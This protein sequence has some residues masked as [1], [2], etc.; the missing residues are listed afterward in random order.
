[1][2]RKKILHSIVIVIAMLSLVCIGW[3]A[4]SQRARELFE[5]ATGAMDETDKAFKE[6][7]NLL[8]QTREADGTATT[9][10][11]ASTENTAV[12]S[13]VYSF[14]ASYCT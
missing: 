7:L 3:W 8:D 1:M 2:M 6:R 11:T 14:V 5:D 9:V 12:G 4:Q 13:D 10:T